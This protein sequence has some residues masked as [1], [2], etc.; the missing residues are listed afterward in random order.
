MDIDGLSWEECI[1]FFTDTLCLDTGIAGV[2]ACIDLYAIAIDFIA[3]LYH[4]PTTI[5][6]GGGIGLLRFLRDDWALVGGAAIWFVLV[7][8]SI[9]FVIGL[10][11]GGRLCLS[12]LFRGCCCRLRTIHQIGDNLVL[13]DSH[14]TFTLFA[15]LKLLGERRLG[16]GCQ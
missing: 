8:S 6:G 12:L 3:A 16:I 4:L 7:C 10:F 5:V 9:I 1:N 2:S 15:L 13:R 14:L 11:G